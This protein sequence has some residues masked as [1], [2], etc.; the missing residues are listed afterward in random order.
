MINETLAEFQ[1]TLVGYLKK[2]FIIAI[3]N[4]NL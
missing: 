1:I 3:V 4:K 2:Y